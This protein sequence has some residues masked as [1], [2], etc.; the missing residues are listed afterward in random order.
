MGPVEHIKM[1]VTIDQCGFK[2]VVIIERPNLYVYFINVEKT[3]EPSMYP[4]H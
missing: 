4:P 3:P 1:R 2:F